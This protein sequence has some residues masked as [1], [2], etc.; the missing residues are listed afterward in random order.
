MAKPVYF[1]E[2]IHQISLGNG[3]HRPAYNGEGIGRFAVSFRGKTLEIL[4]M[5]APKLTE[6]RRFKELGTFTQAVDI[7]RTNFPEVKPYHLETGYFGYFAGCQG[8]MTNAQFQ[9]IDSKLRAVKG[10]HYRHRD[11]GYRNSEALDE[12]IL[13][14][15]RMQG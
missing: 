12:M 6:S 1:S 7:L 14:V 13:R 11:E 8:E 15:T 3:I 10:L 5:L 2:Y 9:E 4:A